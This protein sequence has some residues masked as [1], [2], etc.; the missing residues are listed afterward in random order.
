MLTASRMRTVRPVRYLLGVVLVAVASAAI[1]R[2]QTQTSPQARSTLLR[3]AQPWP[4]ASELRQR[5]A[6]AEALPLFGGEDPI[7]LTFAGDF[8]AV[9]RDRDPNSKKQY[10]MQLTLPRGSGDGESMPVMLSARGHVRRMAQTCDYVPLRVEFPKDRIANTIF[11]G[12]ERL[13]LVVQCRNG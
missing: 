2:A 9:N 5:K 7:A 6:V 10:P 3:L 4:E 1:V 8:R 11:A 13:K 12:Q